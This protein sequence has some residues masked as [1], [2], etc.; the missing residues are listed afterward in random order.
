MPISNIAP[1]LPLIDLHRH[2][3]GSVRLQTIFD[4]ATQ[5]NLP[6]P[7]ADLEGLRPHVQVTEPVPGLLA[8]LQKFDWMTRILV[9]YAACRRIA[10]ENVQDAHAEGLDYIELRFSPWFM[11]ERYGLNPHGVI[12]AVIDGVQAGS[13]DTG[14]PVGLIGILSRTYGAQIAHKELRALLT[15]REHFV[16][17][18]L[19]GDEG[20]YP[21]EWF[22]EHF[23]Q[24]HA[25]GWHVTIHA[26]EARGP[27]SVRQAIEQL[28]AQRIGHA[29]HAARDPQLLE[30]IAAR[31]IGLELNLTS[32]LQTSTIS[33][34]AQHPARQ[35]LELGLCAGL[36]TDDPGI[37][38]IDLAYEYNIAAPAA[39]LSR[40][41]IWQ[42]QHNNLQMAFLSQAE[43][44]Q[45]IEQK[46]LIEQKN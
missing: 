12:E 28:G 26:G 2:L 1:H 7:A 38:A 43:K 19:A 20:N 32:N 36:N 42:A 3:D 5:H 35:F 23:K 17:L 25:A 6:L 15:Y 16:G 41:Q 8:F 30:T 33:G 4:L 9:D 18:D 11:A 46:K 22:V 31:G 21:G 34:Y 27:E 29:V 39:G 40:E 44:T 14:L 10:Y 13:R 24:A 45:L 37:S